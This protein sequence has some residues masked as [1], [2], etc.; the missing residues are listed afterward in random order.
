VTRISVVLCCY[1]G[2]R[3]VAA[4]L[5]SAF[6]Q[7]MPPERYEVVFIDDGSTD[8]TPGIARAFETHPG[9]RYLRNAAN[10]GLVAS[11]N[12]GIEEARSE[13]VVRLDADDTLDPQALELLAAPLERDEADLV[14][15]DR[16]ELTAD[17]GQQRYV[18][19]SHLN[20]F[21]MVACGTMMRRDLALDAGGY[22]DFFWEEYDL[23]I[24][25][26][27]RSG[28]PALHIAKPLYTYTIHEGS[29]TAD[30][31]RVRAGWEELLRT[32][33]LET[34]ERFGR[35]PAAAGS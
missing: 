21:D 34:L 33:P 31:E 4:A 9:F 12:R 30:A 6:R 8:A 13:L 25:Y 23:Y 28:K 22:R 11:A 17:T 24:R 16:F 3:T 20:V 7:T 29:M 15:S 19:V 26:L 18:S 1:N 27:L 35:L 2:E 10:L 14:Y 5:E 32:W